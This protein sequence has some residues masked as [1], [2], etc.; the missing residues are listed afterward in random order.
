MRNHVSFRSTHFENKQTKPNFTNACCF[1]EDLAVWLLTQV[2]DLP[3]ILSEPIQEDYGWGFW[4]GRYFWVAIGIMDEDIGAENPEWLI[5]VAYDPGFSLKQRLFGKP[6][7]AA[8]LQICLSLHATLSAAQDIT[9]IR[10][11]SDG[12]KD[13]GDTPA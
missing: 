11:C 8:Q 2:R 3:Y 13:C 7:R 6:D 12:E 1:G 10:W 4:V 9:E 5:T